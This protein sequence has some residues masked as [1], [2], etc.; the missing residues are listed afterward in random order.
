[1]CLPKLTQ[2][3]FTE[4]KKFTISKYVTGSF[5]RVIGFTRSKYRILNIKIYG[6]QK[7]P[8]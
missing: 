6:H 7:T 3:E 1:M 2:I 4:K 8:S 5:M